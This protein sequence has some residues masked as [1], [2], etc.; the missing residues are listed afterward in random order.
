M[1][2]DALETKLARFLFDYR[3][4]PHYTTGIAPAELLMHRQLKYRL[5]LIKPE[6]G[7]KVTT[8]QTKKKAK[9]DLR[10]KARTFSELFWT[11]N[12]VKVVSRPPLEY[13]V[14]NSNVSYIAHCWTIHTVIK[15]CYCSDQF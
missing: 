5:H 1:H 3:I 2:G 4:T 11:C 7:G 15:E 12:C 14:Y 10:A 9:H 6:V 8:Q 13:F